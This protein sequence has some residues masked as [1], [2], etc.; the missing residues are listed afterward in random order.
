MECL[1]MKCAAL[2]LANEEGRCKGCGGADVSQD[3][4]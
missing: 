3:S 4:G 2:M 1:K